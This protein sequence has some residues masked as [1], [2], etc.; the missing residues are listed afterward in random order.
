MRIHHFTVPAHDPKRVADL[1]AELLGARVV[2]MRHPHGSLLVYAG[3]TDG[4]AIEVWPAATRGVIGGQELALSNLPLPEAWPHHAYVTTDASDADTILAAFAHE[5]WK[6]ERV[7]NG[8]PNAGFGLVR[9]W[10]ENHTPIEIGGREMREEYERFF[11][12][13]TARINLA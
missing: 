7:Y 5:G 6:A 4:S 10:I 9:A 13:A 1:L 2:P 8:P 11:R 3:D 12:E